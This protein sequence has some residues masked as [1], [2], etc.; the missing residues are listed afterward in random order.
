MVWYQYFEMLMKQKPFIASLVF[1]IIYTISNR[2]WCSN[3]QCIFFKKEEET[4]HLK[5]T[6]QRHSNGS[7]GNKC[8]LG[9]SIRTVHVIFGAFVLG[10]FSYSPKPTTLPFD[11][12]TSPFHWSLIQKGN[13]EDTFDLLLT[14]L[15]LFHLG[16]LLRDL[17]WISR[18]SLG[19]AHRHF[20]LLFSWSFS[21]VSI[22]G[23][24]M[25]RP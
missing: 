15:F 6:S 9:E 19:K 5:S 16:W 25:K 4:D 24:N 13:I 18:S 8:Y 23:K 7:N 14:L 2:L 21:S 10:P 11:K 22:P 17:A 1:Q 12:S 3:A 20:T